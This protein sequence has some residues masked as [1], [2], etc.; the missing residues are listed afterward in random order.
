MT[1]PSFRGLGAVACLLLLLAA[2]QG[3]VAQEMQDLR[4][5]AGLDLFPSFLAA[6]KDL[7]DKVGR[8]GTLRLLL[9]YRDDEA[10]AERLKR[11]LDKV[12]SIRKLPFRSAISSNRDFPNRTDGKIAGIF[13]VQRLERARLKPILDYARQEQALVFSPHEG[14]VEQGTVAGIH[15]SD[16]ILPYVNMQA[17]SE[18]GIRLKPFFL[19]IAKKYAQ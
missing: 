12:Q 3:A 16:R 7:G 19:R 1:T 11:L 6:D 4:V 5:G 10:L 15:V 14:D 17:L 13:V 18:G 9:V 8:D 2:R